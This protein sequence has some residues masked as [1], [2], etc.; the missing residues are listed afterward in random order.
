M[1]LKKLGY[2][3]EHY[4]I[5]RDSQC[6]H[7]MAT[8]SEGHSF[9]MEVS[10]FEHS[11]DIEVLKE[12]I[13]IVDTEIIQYYQDIKPLMKTK[14]CFLTHNGLDLTDAV[15]YSLM[16]NDKKIEVPKFKMGERFWM[17]LVYV[18]QEHLVED[19]EPLRLRFFMETH[20]NISKFYDIIK[21]SKY[22]Y[23]LDTNGPYTIFAPDN[24][25][26]GSKEFHDN[27]QIVLY[28]IFPG[29][30]DRDFTGTMVSLG[31]QITEIA[32]GIMQIPN[33]VVKEVEPRFDTLNGNV[34][35]ITSNKLIKPK[36]YKKLP[37]PEEHFII[38]PSDI[39]SSN[40]RLWRSHLD[41]MQ[42]AVNSVKR[43]LEIISSRLQK[44]ESEDS[45]FN[46]IGE[47][48]AILDA[49]TLRDDRDKLH[50]LNIKFIEHVKTAS[51][52]IAI[53]P[54]VDTVARNIKNC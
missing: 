43:D 33:A 20:K 9:I 16:F 19:D 52:L 22:D 7:V 6:T 10:P 28:Y 17:P 39:G 13:T 36:K 51:C 46:E 32:N 2:K 47:K 30:Y 23:L 41:Y 42:I 25:M 4:F 54:Q 26:L 48:I 50:D 35:I 11:S 45:K 44:L 1:D 27:D 15:G 18:K 12:N 40:Y 53:R 38:T 24:D 5:Q 8:T 14:I 21:R 34:T 29:V 37:L 3:V 49:S 31:N